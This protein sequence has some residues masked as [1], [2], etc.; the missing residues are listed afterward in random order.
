MPGVRGRT[1]FSAK[2][3]I[4]KNLFMGPMLWS[5]NV[6]GD[7]VDDILTAILHT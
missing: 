7:F 3:E 2:M 1:T 6:F 4:H 5:M